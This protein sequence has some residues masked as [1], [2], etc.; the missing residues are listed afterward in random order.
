VTS[1]DI[2]VIIYTSGTTGKPK[3]VSL[4]HDNLIS[5]LKGL[6]QMLTDELYH[7]TS[8]AFLP[9]AHVFG[10]VTE[11]QSLLA[12]GSALAIVGHR[13]QILECLPLVRPTLISSVPVLFNKV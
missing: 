5:N 3:G 12:T 2:S 7:H 8:L 1:D 11:L 10:Q 6:R 13:E 9:W 4:S